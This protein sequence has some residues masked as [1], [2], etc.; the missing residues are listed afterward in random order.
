M[1]FLSC[2]RL[3]AG[4]EMPEWDTFFIEW[5]R[6]HIHMHFVIFEHVFYMYLFWNAIA[7]IKIIQHKQTLR[8][9]NILDK[10][11]DKWW[12]AISK[13]QDLV[14][15]QSRTPELQTCILYKMQRPT[16]KIQLRRQNTEFTRFLKW[17][18]Q[19]STY[20]NIR[21]NT[22]LRKWEDFHFLCMAYLFFWSFLNPKLCFIVDS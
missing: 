9:S 12:R 10:I 4:Y 16:S 22:Q 17:N 5:P 1:L 19:T 8:I 18:I 6:T 21:G 2:Y 7:S 11:N 13:L 3:S 14:Q 20:F 15:I